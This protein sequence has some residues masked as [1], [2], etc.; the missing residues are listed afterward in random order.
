MFQLTYAHC[1]K[2]TVGQLDREPWSA[3]E[4]RSVEAVMYRNPP[5]RNMGEEEDD[6]NV[7]VNGRN[8]GWGYDKEEAIS[9]A[10][11]RLMAESR[12]AVINHQLV[13]V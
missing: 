8:M 2:Y 7:Y 1:T 6:F 13:G 11:Y 12:D 4:M 5:D 3:Y 10:G 9:D